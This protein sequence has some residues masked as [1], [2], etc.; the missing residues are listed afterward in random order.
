LKLAIAAVFGLV[1]GAGA[2]GELPNPTAV[3]DLRVLA[4]KSEPAGFL[5]DLQN[6]GSASD[7]ELT[8]QLTALVVDPQGGGQEMTV[9]A[10]GCPDYIDTIT[11][12]TQQ[13]TKLC[14]PASATSQIPE[15]IGSKLTTADAP[16]PPTADPIVAGGYE[17]NPMV[18][19]GLTS[20][21]ISAFFSPD[22]LGIPAIDQS[23]AYNR[24][25]GLP[26]IVNMI[27]DLAGEHAVA[28]KNVVYWPRL[29]AAQQPNKNPTLDGI[30]LFTDRDPMTGNPINEI[31]PAV[32]PMPTVSVSAMSKLY[33][34]PV[35]T[36]A[37]EDYQ[38][39]VKNVDTGLVE[40]RDEHELLR[41]QFYTTAG[42]FDPEMQFSEKNPITNVFHDDSE[43]VLPKAD[44]IPA[45]GIVTIWVVA[46][47]ERAGTDWA[48]RT[49]HVVP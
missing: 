49:I 5:I 38:L 32:D 28:I 12:A 46:H 48:S 27:F 3:V 8:A 41:F 15:P 43:Y 23:V 7:A 47:D 4:I 40:T 16:G 33:V 14:P 18:S 6:P 44:R 10:V 45:D 31:D 34:Q 29:D 1:L 35:Y 26:A 42:T 2:C 39:R 22:P 30:K 36:T 24:D 17:Y 20:D 37:A 25:F 19:F 21:Q 11:S 9:S 13:G